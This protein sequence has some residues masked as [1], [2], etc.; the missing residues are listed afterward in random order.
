[1]D[2]QGQRLIESKAGGED[3]VVEVNRCGTPVIGKRPI[4][5]LTSSRV[6][7]P[8]GLARHP[9]QEIVS[10]SWCI[11][12]R[13]CELR[14][15]V[16]G[17]E[18]IKSRVSLTALHV[19]EGANRRRFPTWS[20]ANLRNAYGHSP[21]LWNQSSGVVREGITVFGLYH[22][23]EIEIVSRH[24]P[25]F[26]CRRR[27][28]IE[29]FVCGA[30]EI[31]QCVSH[32]L[33]NERRSIVLRTIEILA[34]ELT[35]S[36]GKPFVQTAFFHAPGVEAVRVCVWEAARTTHLTYAA[37]FRPSSRSEHGCMG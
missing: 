33:E 21:K 34:G 19:V 17:A 28:R 6:H 23:F 36:C 11:T 25:H 26:G 29:R 16:N 1:M 3:L 12:G 9:V 4:K 37:F 8:E 35:D 30:E 15:V 14:R 2:M 31:V 13:H 18:L 32:R 22:R 5:P 7:A 20:K 27:R 10:L 24:Y